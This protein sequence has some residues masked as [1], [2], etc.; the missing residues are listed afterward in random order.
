MLPKPNPM[1]A[2]TATKTAVQAPWMETE[3]KEI[4]MPSMPEAEQ[5]IQSSFR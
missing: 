2:A 3:L 1:I 5:Q 4:E